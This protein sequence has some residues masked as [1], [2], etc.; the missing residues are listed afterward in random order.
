M[1]KIEEERGREI[2]RINILLISGQLL[3]SLRVADIKLLLSAIE[4]DKKSNCLT[5]A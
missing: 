2:K 1:S 4:N 5:N 3:C